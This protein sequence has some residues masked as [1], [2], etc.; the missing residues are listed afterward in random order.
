MFIRCRHLKKISRLSSRF[1]PGNPCDRFRRSFTV[2]AAS[3]AP[4]SA[5]DTVIV[6][7]PLLGENFSRGFST[8]PQ[9]SQ[10]SSQHVDLLSY[11]KSAIDELQGPS[12]YW[13]N[14]DKENKRFFN[15]KATYL[16]VAGQWLNGISDLNSVVENVKLLQQRFPDVYF[17]GINFS[18]QARTVD[19]RFEL[20]NL[21]VKEYL[22][23][24]MLLSEK[25]FPEAAGEVCYIISREFE[26]P[27]IY[28]EKDLDISVLSRAL[29]ESLAH[30]NEKPKSVKLFSNTWSKQADNIKESHFCS[31]FQDLLLYFPGCISADITGDRLFLSDS[32][33]HRILILDSSGKILDSIGCCP[34]FEDGEFESAKMLRPAASLYD[35][36]EDC[37]YI[38]DSE[39]HAI[40]RADMERRVLETVYPKQSERNNSG[41]WSWVMNKLGLRKDDDTTV[42]ANAKSDE[43][44]AHSLIF[45]WHILKHDDDSLLVINKSFQ[46]LWM[47]NLT[48]GEIEEVVEGIPKILEICGQL[49]MEKL[50]HL[51]H[52]PPGWLQQQTEALSSCKEI[53]AAA[54]LSSFTN[55][56]DDTVMAD[57]AGQRVLKL[58]RKS[59]A[60]SSIQFS[61]LGI[62]GLP[63]WL[64]IPL[65]R[66]YALS[67]GARKAAF[68]HTQRFQLLP[69]KVKARLNIEIP[70]GT[71]LVEPLQE[72][73]I[74][75]QARGSATDMSVSET[76]EEPSEKVGVSQQWYDELDNLAF[77]TLNDEVAAEEES[78]D[79]DK[80]SEVNSDEKHVNINCIVNISP[81]TSQLIV[82]AALYLRLTRSSN[83]EDANREELASRIANIIVNQDRNTK[84]MGRDVF[85]KLLSE[86]SGD[87]RDLVFMKPVSVA[88]SLDS[89]DHPKAD[90]SRDIILTDSSIE[91]HVSL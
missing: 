56:G 42:P 79:K 28:H 90:N 10:A 11:I 85:I 57:I 9:V 2:S 88:I 45:P 54:F 73:C 80:P 1:V 17:V 22:T 74:W 24:P 31:P 77:Q 81:G 15:R 23:F 21:I 41:I 86:S 40:R 72:S 87:L 89:M 27:L 35:E 64:A 19:D 7:K 37:L 82:Y 63:Y 18:N 6:P 69:G 68:S 25:E 83:S 61:N 33:H 70:A 13:L 12:H 58:N 50:S 78:D 65:E 39:N 51:K 29:E 48:S 53:P 5:T 16:V 43:F 26:N 44:D 60:C 91:V 20:Y 75:R 76:A 62:L 59:G 32:N 46:K 52:L 49:I 66:V 47:M 36:E 67:N 34:G 84:N 30:D 14:L 55:L 3:L 8:I 71:E 4:L 38:V